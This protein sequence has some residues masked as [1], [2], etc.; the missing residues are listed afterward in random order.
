MSEYIKNINVF[1]G[2]NSEKHSMKLS[3]WIPSMI[4]QSTGFNLPMKAA[5]FAVILLFSEGMSGAVEVRY[6]SSDGDDASDGLSQATQKIATPFAIVDGA[7]VRRWFDSFAATDDELYTNA[8]PN[9]V[10]ANWALSNIPRFECPDRE[11]ER[12][13]Y[14]RWWTY[15]KHLRNTKDG[16]VVTEFLPSV[17]WAALNNTISCALNHHAAEG[18]WLRDPQYLDGYL[19][20]MMEHGRVSGCGSYSCAPAYAVLERAKVTGDFDFEKSLLPLFEKN[21]EVWEAGW[22]SIGESFFI[23]YRPERGLYDIYGG[24]EGTEYNLSANGARPMV[25]SMRWADL[26][27]TAKIA[28]MAG[29][30]AGE[31]KGLQPFDVLR[32]CGFWSLRNRRRRGRQA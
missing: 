23:G 26:D 20:F 5:F 8:I 21:C 14:F 1:P 6:L 9:A 32:S 18:R 4:A 17:P 10:A 30:S 15:R 29:R 7:K 3:E 12:T 31:R 2:S 25:N 16:W 22:R 19:R 27:A 11:I 13:Y 28:A 24:W